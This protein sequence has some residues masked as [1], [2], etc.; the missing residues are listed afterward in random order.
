MGIWGIFHTVKSFLSVFEG[1]WSIRVLW[2]MKHYTC[3]QSQEEKNGHTQI[4]IF[5]GGG[6]KVALNRQ[7]HKINT[8]CVCLYRGGAT[9]NIKISTLT[10]NIW[11]ILYYVYTSIPK[12]EDPK[13]LLTH[14][15]LT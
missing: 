2:N 3:D 13:I 5:F 4:I 1:F 12:M 6:N 10:R 11:Y 7:K 15:I 9:L 14:I 8:R